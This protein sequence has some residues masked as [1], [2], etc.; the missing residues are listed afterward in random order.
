MLQQCC[1]EASFAITGRN[2]LQGCSGGPQPLK[3]LP[4]ARHRK[5][6]ITLPDKILQGRG[7]LMVPS[8]SLSV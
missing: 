7:C 5:A 4:P 6:M 8:P 2:V 3:L 1:S